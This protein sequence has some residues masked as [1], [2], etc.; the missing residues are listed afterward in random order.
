M[1]RAFAI[2]VFRAL[3]QLVSAPDGTLSL[4]KISYLV[5]VYIFSQAMAAKMPDDPLLWLVYGSTVG[6]VEVA[7]KYISSRYI[8][9]ASG[10][11]GQGAGGAA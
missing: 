7:K 8:G 6:G 11:P 5:F 2:V 9:Q 1:S 3:L 10:T 4:S